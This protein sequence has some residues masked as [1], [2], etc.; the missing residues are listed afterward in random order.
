MIPGKIT[1]ENI[2]QL[3]SRYS[4]AEL[5]EMTVKFPYFREAHIL[6][7]KKYQQ[8]NNPKF[9]QQLQVAALYTNDRQLLFNLFNEKPNRQK[10][11]FTFESIST[12]SENK[13]EE[14]FVPVA[15]QSAENIIDTPQDL[16]EHEPIVAEHQKV[17]EEPITEEVVLTATQTPDIEE[18]IAVDE[19]IVLEDRETTAQEHETVI[20]NK[21]VDTIEEQSVVEEIPVM[22][23]ELTEPVIEPQFVEP[24]N[25]TVIEESTGFEEEEPVVKEEEIVEE[26]VLEEEEIESAITPQDTFEDV[27]EYQETEITSEE[28]VAKAQVEVITF[29]KLEEHTFEDWLKYFNK[30]GNK[31][32]DVPKPTDE[33]QAI[34][35]A[36][37]NKLIA[38]SVP[39]NI[40][41][42]AVEGE[43]RY[44]KGLDKFIEEQISIKKAKPLKK[45]KAKGGDEADLDPALVTETLARLYEAQRK[46][47][48]AIRAYEIL[49]LK[50]PE[51]SDL[52]AARINYLKSLLI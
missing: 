17:T 40:L 20:E 31:V 32:T 3:L 50:F 1:T 38:T 7:A 42:E 49:T 43:T 27:V 46:Y 2:G 48:R 37:L 19:P 23:Q 45:A 15:E 28:Q 5:E 8:E 22:E 11:S 41:H 36:E 6:L 51:K 44:S 52:F 13:S 47:G 4:T 25:E 34:A 14:I 30:P 33:E 10:S 35:D 9:D 12:E 39:L 24:E 29:N 26:E 18:D 21:P 16:M